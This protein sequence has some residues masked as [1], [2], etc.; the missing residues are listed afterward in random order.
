MLCTMM[1]PL[2]PFFTELMYQNL[3]LVIV[4]APASVHYLMMPYP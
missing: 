4:D 1:S 2:T 3:R